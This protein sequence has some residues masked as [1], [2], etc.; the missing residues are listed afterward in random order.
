MRTPTIAT[1]HGRVSSPIGTLLV[2]TTG[3]ALSGLYVADHERAPQPPIDSN[4]GGPFV[5]MVCAQ[6]TEY[7]EGSRT[8]FDLPLYLEGTEFQRRVWQALLEVPFGRTASYLDIAVTLGKPTAV[9]AVGLANGSNPVSIVVPCHRVVGSNGSLTGYGWGTE[10]KRW[11][12]DF[13]RTP[14]LL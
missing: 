10:R 9:R 3:D 13:E 14:R 6:I 8:E 1:N 12:L 2:L 11:L 5:D 7:F 4:E